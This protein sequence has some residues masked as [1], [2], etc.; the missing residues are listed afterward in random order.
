M[1]AH[2]R[3]P[4]PI[5]LRVG[6]EQG[7]QLGGDLGIVRSSLEGLG[8]E[9]NRGRIVAATLQDIRLNR[10]ELAVPDVGR[11]AQ[12]FD[13]RIDLFPVPLRFGATQLVLDPEVKQGGPE[14]LHARELFHGLKRC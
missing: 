11:R 1:H 6:D 5:D 7:H 13:E 12:E 9:L 8:Y 4:G 14:Q 2:D 3:L 10:R